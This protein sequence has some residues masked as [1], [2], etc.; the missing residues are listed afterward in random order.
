MRKRQAGSLWGFAPASTK[1]QG[2]AIFHPVRAPHQRA[3]MLQQP[4]LILDPPSIAGERSVGANRAMARDYDCDRVGTVRMA[5]RARTIGPADPACNFAVGSGRA[6]RYGAQLDPHRGLK[7]R[8]PDIDRNLQF[9]P[10][11]NRERCDFPRD[12]RAPAVAGRNLSSRTIRSQFRFQVGARLVDAEPREAATSR[13]RQD[14]PKR[15][16][17]NRITHPRA[18]PAR[19]ITRPGNSQLAVLATVTHVTATGVHLHHLP[20][21]RACVQFQPR[22]A[23]LVNRC[24]F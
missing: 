6:A 8:R 11:A 9:R 1:G 22:T 15:R 21:A 2:T 4:P 5:D 18:R 10:V 3:F 14:L 17:D 13:R 24:R 12:P 7:R 23:S 20:F 19:T 16:I